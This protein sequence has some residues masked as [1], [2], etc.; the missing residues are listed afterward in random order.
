MEWGNCLKDAGNGNKVATIACIPTVFSILIN[1]A[2]I[3]AG[4]VALFFIIYA[5]IKFV[6]SG[7]DPKQVEGARSTL[8]WAVI[9]LVICL[10][11]FFIVRIISIATSTP[12]IKTFGFTNC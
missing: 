8:T 7:G 2:L 12:C 11:A 9:G 3:L 1:N 4:I 6:T 5:G 10:L